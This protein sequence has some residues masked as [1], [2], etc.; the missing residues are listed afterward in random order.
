MKKNRYLLSKAFLL[1]VGLHLICLAPLLY[2]A[3]RKENSSNTDN[4]LSS[5]QRIA[6]M[7]STISLHFFRK[8]YRKRI[9]QTNST[10][11]DTEQAK[12]LLQNLYSDIRK[13][14]IKNAYFPEQARLIRIEDTVQIS[15]VLERDGTIHDIK[16]TQES[17][18]H[19]F[20]VAAIEIIRSISPVSS[21]HLK[22]M[23][24]QQQ[25]SVPVS[26]SLK[27]R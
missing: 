17:K 16:L 13:E 26:F 6:K 15:F 2:S 23:T 3:I 1:S 20:N 4:P 19:P 9:D 10:A 22:E 27:Q 21:T 24:H 8:D 5:T 14:I 25:I 12:Q 7:S 18:F 11:T